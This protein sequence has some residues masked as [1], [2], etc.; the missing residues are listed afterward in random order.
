MRITSLLMRF[1][2]LTTSYVLCAMNQLQIVDKQ[3]QQHR[4]E[5]AGQQVIQHN[6]QSPA[7]LPVAPCN[8]PGFENVE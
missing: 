5:Q 1:V 4:R 3:L 2:S 7:D 6:P 8:R